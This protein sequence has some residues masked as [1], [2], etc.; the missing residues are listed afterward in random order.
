MTRL[1]KMTRRLFVMAA[2]VA[3]LAVGVSA[4]SKS[5][6]PKGKGFDDVVK[7]LEK[8]QGAKKTKVPMLGLAKFAVRLVRPAGVKGFKL[9]IYEDQDFKARG[10]KI[11]FGQVMRQ[12]YNKDWSPLVQLHS[13]RDGDTRTYIYVKQSKKDVEFA[14]ATL[15]ENEAVL[16]QVKFNPDAAARFLE[17]PKIM[18]ISLGNSIRGGNNNTIAGTP[19]ARVNRP[20]PQASSGASGSQS[21]DRIVIQDGNATGENRN[22][23][24][25]ARPALSVANDENSP[26]VP[27][28]AEAKTPDA[29]PVEPVD[30]KPR[31]DTLSIETRLVNLNVKALDKA[32]QPIT[33]LKPEDFNIYEDGIKQEVSHFKPVNAPVS[34]I[35]LLDL[36]GST[37][38]KRKAMIEAAHRFIDTLPAGDKISVVAFTRTYRP[39]TGFTADKPTLKAAVNQIAK[40]GGGTAFYDAAWKSLDQLQKLGE[41]RKAIVVLTDGEDESL[42]S[43][44]ETTHTFDELLG[45]ASEEDVTIY[46][47]YF[48]PQQ[49]AMNT[50]GA[51]FGNGS[52]LGGND[53]GKQARKQLE[54]LAEQTGGEIFSAQREE[55]LESAYKLVANELHTLYSLAYSP[56]KPKHDGQF[57]KINIKLTREGSVAKTRRG[58]YDK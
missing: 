10:E 28:T 43:N 27:A 44:R 12:A 14:V 36:S 18:G 45:R 9:A 35:L 20:A 38:K 11:P 29:K 55:D 56:D 24:S 54:Q 58:Y 37:Q 41:A 5:F 1:K 31:E 22:S 6:V 51:L 21:L 53:R 4:Q 13:K 52:L 30:A 49:H 15:A 42:I 25:T 32:G 46:P 23:Q 3:L 50:V 33:N 8:N 16:V 57:R 26:P 19:N 7:H 40:I 2:M 39:L 47:I 48:S 17:N 34:L